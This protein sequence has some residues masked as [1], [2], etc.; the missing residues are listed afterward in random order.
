MLGTVDRRKGVN[1]GVYAV[2]FCQLF[3]LVY[4]PGFTRKVVHNYG[5]ERTTPAAVEL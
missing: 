1:D 3:V 2:V 4:F 5:T